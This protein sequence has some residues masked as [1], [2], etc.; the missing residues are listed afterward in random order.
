MID[1]ISQ[2]RMGV[3]SAKE[4]V[5]ITEDMEDVVRQVQ[6]LNEK[7]VAARTAWRKK[8]VQVKGEY[9]FVNAVDE[10][11]RV[12]EAMDL[13]DQLKQ[14]TVRKWGAAAW[15]EVEKI[16]ARQKEELK[17]IYTDE[18]HD[19]AKLRQ[20]TFVWFALSGIL[21]GWLWVAGYIRQWS[22]VVFPE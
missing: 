22:M 18:G 9:A 16:E 4:L 11:K 19:R 1:P 3:D 12:R 21:V 17:K 5:A 20:A 15:A 2:L 6:Q 10:Y 8:E 13:R 7:T 14:E